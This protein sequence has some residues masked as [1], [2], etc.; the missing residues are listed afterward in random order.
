MKSLRLP[1]RNLIPQSDALKNRFFAE[2]ETNKLTIILGKVN[3]TNHDRNLITMDVKLIMLVLT[4]VFT[5]AC[6]FFGTKGGY[7]DT[8]KY[9]GN[10]SAH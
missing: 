6:L 9:D 5:V 1:L 3:I 7:Y 8:D 4:A 2:L 10:G